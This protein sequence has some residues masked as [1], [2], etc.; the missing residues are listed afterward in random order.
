MKD[1]V[2][3]FAGEDEESLLLEM[4]IREKE[5]G[6]L[7]VKKTIWALEN[8]KDEFVYAIHELGDFIMAIK[9]ESYLDAL[10]KNFE[11][12][13]GY[14]EYELCIQS[15]KWIEYLKIEENVNANR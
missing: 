14:E 9:R 3:E 8:N 7:L 1:K 4:K 6:I 5:M 11:K 2:I 12:I 15:N 13:E 10:E